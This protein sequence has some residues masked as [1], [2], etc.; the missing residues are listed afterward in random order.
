MEKALKIAKNAGWD[1]SYTKSDTCSISDILLDPEFWK[2]LGLGLN[3]SQ[4][5]VLLFN[6]SYCE[7]ELKYQAYRFINHILDGKDTESF[8][9]ELLKHQF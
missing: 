7:S 8:F 6:H 5:P 1:S 3:W 9:K 4:E 2:C